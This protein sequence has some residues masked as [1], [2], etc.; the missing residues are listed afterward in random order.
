MMSTA[1]K[2]SRRMKALIFPLANVN[3]MVFVGWQIGKEDMVC[4]TRVYSP[5][6]YFFQYSG[7]DI[8]GRDGTIVS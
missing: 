4:G 7:I 1:T 8:E 3:G 2:Y 6:N 5:S